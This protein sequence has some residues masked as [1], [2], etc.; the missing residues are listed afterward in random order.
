MGT[1]TMAHARQEAVPALKRH[2]G[3]TICTANSTLVDVGAAGSTTMHRAIMLNQIPNAGG[4]PIVL[5]K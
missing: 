4:D 2:L 1:H 5:M 3:T